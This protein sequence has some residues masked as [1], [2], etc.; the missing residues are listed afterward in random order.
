MATRTQLL[1]AV[2][3]YRDRAERNAALRIKKRRTIK[4]R[5]ARTSRKRNGKV[6]LN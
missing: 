6:G 3:K 2:Q 4:N 5:M 1:N